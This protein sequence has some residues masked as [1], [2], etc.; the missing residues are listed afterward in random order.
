MSSQHSSP[1][2]LM[3][4]NYPKGTGYAWWLMECFWE[5]IAKAGAAAGWRS[6]IAYPPDATQDFDCQNSFDLD[7]LEAFLSAGRWRDLL[8]VYRLTR[9]LNIRSIYLTDRPFRSWKYGWLKIAGIR[10]IVVHDHTPGDRPAINGIKGLAKRVLNA[11]SWLTA[12]LYVSV[13]PLMRQRH[14][15]NAKIPPSRCVTVTNGLAVRE[16]IPNARELLLAQFGLSAESFIVGAI[17]RLNPYKRFDFAIR[18]IAQLAREHPENQPVLILLGDG[19]D[20]AR[21]EDLAQSLGSS[22]RV[23]FAGQLAD[24]WPILCGIDAVIHPSSGEGLSLAILEAMAAARPVVVPS[25][26]SVAQTIDD[27]FTGF[28]YQ[29]GDLVGAK[30]LLHDLFINKTFRSSIGQNARQK[31]LDNYQLHRTLEDF[32]TTVIPLLLKD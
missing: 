25:L 29:N 7:R 30:K 24:T 21:L 16:P 5:A 10:S 27:S 3:V 11:S 12:D 8:D 17:G 18:C 28:I 9:R 26:P 2:V 14:L 15:L 19:P 20:R 6:A 4:A 13:S 32:R 1:M 31:I 23:I 22:S